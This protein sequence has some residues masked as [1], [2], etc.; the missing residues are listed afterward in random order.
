MLRKDRNRKTD[1]KQSGIVS[2][3]VLAVLLAWS[4]AFGAAA[5]EGMSQAETEA[6][7]S[8]ETEF[9]NVKEFLAD[10]EAVV[11]DRLAISDSY[12]EAELRMMTN[13]EIAEANQACCE[14][15]RWFMNYYRNARFE[16]RNIQYL[17]D[18]YL[19]GLQNQFDAYDSWKE[20][21]DIDAYNELWEAGFSKRAVA[22]VELKDFYGASF[23]DISDMQKKADELETLDEPVKQKASEETIRKVQED[24]NKLKFPVGSVDGDCGYR[25]VQMVRRFQK[26]YGYGPADGILDE[27]LLSQLE[28]EVKK[29]SPEEEETEETETTAGETKTETEAK[30]ETEVSAQDSA[31]TETEASQEKER[32]G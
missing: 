29:I 12:T 21:Q 22:V 14:S 2:A 1:R 27:D 10:I 18:Q 6:E 28:A 8:A 15:E 24:L 23:T 7:S 5:A 17:C 13:D 16:S 30:T 4:L 11:N 32:Q 26:L 19:T 25:T 31:E 9:A 3:A 20:K